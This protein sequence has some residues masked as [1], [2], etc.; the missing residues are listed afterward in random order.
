MIAACGKDNIVEYTET[1]NP[2]D[3]VENIAFTRT[4]DVVFST[5]ETALVTGVTSDFETTISD[6][7][8]TI[9]NNG[10][11]AVQY[12]V[13]GTT[14]NGYLKIYSTEK[15]AICLNSATIKNSS[16]AAINIQGS[17]NY[18]SSGKRTY[19]VI[20]GTCELADG[21]TYSETPSDEDEKAA[22]FSEGA[23]LI[24]GT[25]SL[26]VTAIG[27]S[28][29]TSDSYARIL[30]SPTVAINTTSGHGIRGKNKVIVS[31]G[32]L[33]ITTSAD[34]KKGITSDGSVTISGGTTTLKV[35]GNA[36]YDSEE[37]DYDG[38][39][40]IKSSDA[41]SM[42]GGTLTI[43]NTGSGGKG[44]SGDGTGV[45]SGGTVTVTTTGSN[46]T[47]GDISAKGIKF[48]GDLTFSGST[49][50]VSSASHEAI[51]SKGS[52]KVTGGVVY[53]YSAA[54]DGINS[55]GDFTIEDGMVCAHATSN[56]GMD[57]NGNFYVKGG[58]VYAIGASQPEVGIDA[59]TEGGYKLYLTG[60]TLLAIGGLENNSS[61]TQTCYSTSS[62]SA[63]TWY[64]LT[65]GDN[66]Y[67]FKTPSNGG[68]GLV[69]SG[70]SQPSLTSGITVSGGTSYFNGTFTVGGDI[71]GGSS[72]S[73]SEYT[74]GNG[75]GGNPGGPGG[76][77]NPGGGPGH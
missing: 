24:S 30:D 15:Q 66:T 43:T 39:A 2:N 72:V 59:N 55:A 67:A 9:V 62:W 38:T 53:G 40:G 65:V 50:S 18:P 73:M 8:V 12:N 63:N 56:D 46:Y 49:V 5:S 21:T 48:D 4:V 44:I 64:G 10:T 70:S 60:G 6:N 13:S 33:D 71:S 74:G 20:S 16:G 61:L 76:G 22:L 14:N 57:A 19:I 27:K 3:Y 11:D 36:T 69:V 1:D 58:I 77:G 29:I 28:G 31:G 42:S 68:N 52:I 25:G 41:F 35:S 54:D 47:T 17:K 45:F 32:M 37:S 34:G 23:L 75:G 51:E 7:C 26:T